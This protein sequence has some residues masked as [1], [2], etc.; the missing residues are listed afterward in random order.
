[1]NSPLD[2]PDQDLTNQSEPLKVWMALLHNVSYLQNIRLTKFTW[3][4][5]RVYLYAYWVPK[6]FIRLLHKNKRHFLL[7]TLT[8]SLVRQ[9]LLAVIARLPMTAHINSYIC[10]P[11]TY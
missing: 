8:C 1:M 6:E 5:K 4:K 3:D 11:R 10:V 7:S 2:N 9:R